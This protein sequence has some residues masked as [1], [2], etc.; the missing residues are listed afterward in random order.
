[1][2]LSVAFLAILSGAAARDIFVSPTGTGTGTQTAP[3]GSIQSAVNAAVAGDTIYLRQGTYAPSAN[4]QFSKSGTVTS[5]ICVR[6][7]QSEK[8]I[9]DGENM[10]GT[11]K[12]LDE[13][14]PNSE[15]GIFHIQNANYWAF[16]DLEMINGPY[17]IYARD[18]SHNYYNG[19]STHDNYETGFQLEGASS[20]N[21]VLNLDSYRNR[22]PRKNGESADGFA[23]KSGSGEGNVLRNARLWDNVDDGLD[24][25][26]FASP[27][28]LEEV[29]S[30]GNGYNRWGFSPFEGDGNGF[31]LGITDNP[32]ANHVVRNSIAF[33][34]FKKGFID[35]GNPDVVG[36]TPERSSAQG[37]T[38]AKTVGTLAKAPSVPTRDG[39]GKSSYIDGLL[40]EIRRLKSQNAQSAP[41]S[42]RD[43]VSQITTQTNTSSYIGNKV[44][45]PSSGRGGS[46]NEEPSEAATLEVR[47]WFM[48][49]NV[50]R[51]PI[52]ISEVADAAFTTRFRQVI[53]DPEEP[54]PKH[55]LRLNYAPDKELMTLVKS[56][57]PWPTPSRSRFLV[58]V[59]LKYVSRRYHVVRRSSIMENLEQSI[60]NPSWGDLMLRSKLWALFAIGELYS[61]RSIPSERDFPGM[62][63]FAKASRILGLLDERPGTDSIEIMLLLSFYSLV[64]NRRYSAFVMSGTAMRMAIVMGLHL[65]IPESQLRDPD[66][67]EHRKRLFWTTYIFDRVWASKLGHPSAIQDNDIGVDLPSEPVVGQ[68]FGADFD[69]AAY[70]I[71][72]LRLA[73]LVT[74][75][76]RSIY[77]QRN[78][79]DATLSTRVQQALKDL[80]AWVEDLPTHLQIDNPD[81]GP[82][83]ISLHLSFNQC[84][85][86]ATRPILLHILRTQ[87][88]SWPSS[89][90]VTD[91]QVP[92]SAITLS[93]A[94]I[95]CAR[96]SIRLLTDSWI[97]GSFATFD[98]FYTQ[99]LFSALT[100]LAASSLLDGPESRSD[101]EAFEESARFLSQLRDAG[102]F[103]AQEYCHHV[104]VMKADLDKVYAK[105]MGLALGEQHTRG[106]AAEDVSSRFTGVGSAMSQFG[107]APMLPAHTTAGMALTEPSLE[108][109]LAQPVLDLQFLEASFYDDHQGLYWPD[110]ST[111]NWNDLA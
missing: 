41:S 19:L 62:A 83:P 96:H 1:M 53:S 69:D 10:P 50:F 29:Y 12:A 76:V 36:V 81:S 9:I 75:T 49:A 42:I 40:D 98:Y 101:R 77:G 38:R 63:Y 72:N 71:A 79:G 88:A 104:D 87:V 24:L 35:N 61:T 6:P 105:R 89:S 58:E 8:V 2:G 59:A 107:P 25:F 86:L 32:P 95:R 60:H 14:L 100:I 66:L 56:D 74:K 91:A 43:D 110:F 97:D 5:P 109:L 93:E 54:Q 11:P 92:A 64:L 102:N 52:L 27:V 103:A 23:C 18:A 94:C 106:L 46:D 73:A 84:A 85:I 111:E 13:S 44:T 57:I 28:T 17:G 31:K 21:T 67:R 34:N 108:E 37:S 47:P 22:D 82:K 51:T 3:Y 26:M 78:Q 7:Y 15:R 80:R 4:T 70:H 90:P 99:Y 39:I 65:N 30:W 48:N 33:G 45:T 68:T 55:I 16:Y 20:N